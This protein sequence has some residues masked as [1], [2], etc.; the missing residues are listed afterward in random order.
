M[1]LLRLIKRVL[2]YLIHSSAIYV[3]VYNVCHSFPITS[4]LLGRE[5]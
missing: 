3:R 5:P 4:V 2:V 1:W